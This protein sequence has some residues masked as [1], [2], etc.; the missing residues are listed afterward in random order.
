ML[1][2]GDRLE[3][4]RACGLDPAD[5]LDDDVDV[6]MS[7]HDAGVV[8]QVDA[9]RTARLL[10]RDVDRARSAIHVMRIGRPAR[11]EIS[12][13]FRRSTVHVPKPTVPMPSKPTLSGFMALGKLACG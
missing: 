13:S 10:A 9:F 6:R 8:G 1:A 4:Q 3:H 2:V 11:R 5:Q 7:E 12:S